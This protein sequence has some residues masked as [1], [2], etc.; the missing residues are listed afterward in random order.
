MLLGYQQTSSRSLIVEERGWDSWYSITPRPSTR[1]LVPQHLR[2]RQ[3]DGRRSRSIIPRPLHNSRPLLLG[4]PMMFVHDGS[5]WLSL[6]AWR[7]DSI[8]P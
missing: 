5:R 3:A 4:I 8:W 1:L 6:T 7:N 2:I